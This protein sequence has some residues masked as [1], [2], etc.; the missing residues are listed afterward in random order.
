MNFDPFFID[1]AL[2]LHCDGTNGSSSFP[3]SSL[4]SLPVTVTNVTVDTS[5]PEFGTG[6]MTLG[7]VA[8]N[9]NH[10]SI[11]AVPAGPLDLTNT[12]F[13]VEFWFKALALEAGQSRQLMGDNNTTTPN[14]EIQWSGASQTIYFAA[15]NS[16]TQYS[17]IGPVITLNTN[18]WHAAACVKS[19]ANIT[20]YV[21][22]IAGVTAPM[23]GGG[24]LIAGSGT[25]QIGAYTSETGNRN[26]PGE[27]DEIRISR[28]ARYSANYIPAGP[29]SGSGGQGDIT[30]PA[31]WQD[32]SGNIPPSAFQNVP[33]NV[34][35]PLN[36]DGR[37]WFIANAQNPTPQPITFIGDPN[38]A[39]TGT[40]ALQ[41]S[42]T[43]EATDGSV[44]YVAY[45]TDAGATFTNTALGPL[46]QNKGLVNNQIVI[47]LAG[48][49]GL[50]VKAYSA[51]GTPSA[52][53]KAWNVAIA[54]TRNVNESIAWDSPNPFDPVN[55]NAA[56]MDNV[57]PTDTLI[58]LRKR[59]INRLGFITPNTI[60]TGSTFL[61][62]QTRV[63]ARCGFKTLLAEHTG[64]TLLQ[65]QTYLLQ[66]LGFSNQTANPPP[67]IANL[68]TA[69][70]NEAQQGL[71]R[72]YAQDGY[73]DAAPA[74]LVNP[75]DV[76]TLDNLAVQISSTAIGKAHYGQP[77]S[78]VIGNQ[79][80]TYL[81]E[82]MLRTPP[83]LTTVVQQSINDAMQTIWRRYGYEVNGIIT[84][85]PPTPLAA[86]GDVCTIDG[87]TVE[88]A[89]VALV[90]AYYGQKDA[91]AV[92]GQVETY[93]A[94]LLKRQPPNLAAVVNDFLNEGQIYLYRRYL[95]LHTKR[96]FRW[97]VNPGQR[98]YSLKDNDEDVLCNFTMDPLKSIEWVGIQDSRNVWY[99]LI[100]GIPPQ[101]YTMI[102]KPWRPARYDIRQAIE[103]YP[104]PDQTYWLWIK[105]HFGLMSFVNDSD[106]TTIDCN[107]VFLHALANAKA[108]YGQPDAANIAAQANAYRAELIAGTHQTAHY[109]PG[110]IAVP[111]AVRPTLIQFDQGG[112]GG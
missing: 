108:H 104:M 82:L 33:Q 62:L 95:Q 105:G 75:S 111:P 63:I 73:A 56:C 28:I 49:T 94:E 13:T 37:Y 31:A 72:R 38:F 34:S 15:A 5:A 79:F 64:K 85:A 61:Q 8:V 39:S 57:V 98:F 89:A 83:N 76:L 12:D 54:I 99:P 53:A 22:G 60:D 19:G 50:I 107:L 48:A 29:F 51:G 14:W 67:G 4:N 110:T 18:V 23:A 92:A 90:K 30:D 93:L 10:C 103:L 58:D 100:Q 74:D 86:S 36:G 87:Q 66:R 20:V 81:K 91:Q 41:C 52:S 77:D 27:L 43:Q 97:K 17:A 65:M 106:T 40:M 88:T 69:I 96:F 80:E 59:I 25:M 3:D 24:V 44:L 32:T 84:G 2:L 55:Y 45:S 11:P 68:M 101:L 42:I 109:L 9:A 71:W 78:Q 70:I 102:T 16:T 7:A 112:S 21:D 6:A 26:F 47:P 35:F 46:V 1:V